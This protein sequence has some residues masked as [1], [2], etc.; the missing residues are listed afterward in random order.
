M[1]TLGLASR[2]HRLEGEA[3][4]VHVDVDGGALIIIHTGCGARRSLTI[5]PSLL[6]VVNKPRF[7]DSP[8]RPGADGIM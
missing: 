8:D 6:A 2:G 7:V 5:S 1:G 4:I 3:R